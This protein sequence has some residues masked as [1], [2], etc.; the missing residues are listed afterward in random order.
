MENQES[1]NS[2]STNKAV[3][4]SINLTPE[5]INELE[6]TFGKELTKRI[7]DIKIDKIEGYLSSSVHVN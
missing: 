1:E 4:V 2:A 6:K 7:K 5:Q 3:K